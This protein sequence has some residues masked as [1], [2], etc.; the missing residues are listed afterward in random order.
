MELVVILISSVLINNFVLV[1][2]L[3]ICPFLGVSGK[4]DSAW[5]MGIAVT[6]VMALTAVVCWPIYHLILLP[7]KLDFLQ[8]IVFILVIACLVQFVEM[9]IR[10]TAPPLYNAMGIY[11]PLITTNCAI[12]GFILISV[13]RNYGYL[14]TIVYGVGS[15]LGFTL[16]LVIM[17]GIREELRFADIPK[18]MQG[19]GIT[20]LIASIMALAFSGFA[21]LI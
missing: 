8:I 4:L 14:E 7:S 3:G 17:A 13:L 18:P 12:L 16:A 11:L 20:L 10:K 21:G 19:P 5:S 2:F 6:F 15:G 1:Q 9:F